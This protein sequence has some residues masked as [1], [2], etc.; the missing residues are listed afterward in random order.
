MTCRCSTSTS[1]RLVASSAALLL[2]LLGCAN[3]M[4][5]STAIDGIVW[6]PDHATLHPNGD[7]DKIGARELLIQWTQVGQSAFIAGASANHTGLASGDTSDT[8]D[9]SNAAALPDR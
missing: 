6:Q 5:A 1:S 8:S 4:P 7:W 2:A 3:G 9:A